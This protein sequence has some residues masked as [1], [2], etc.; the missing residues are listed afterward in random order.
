MTCRKVTGEK[1]TVVSV[2]N[3][4]VTMEHERREVYA[5]GGNM[6][7]SNEVRVDDEKEVNNRDDDRKKRGRKERNDRESGSGKVGS[8]FAEKIYLKG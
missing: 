2:E 5:T 8:N 3:E 1:V 6:K 4:G 7:R